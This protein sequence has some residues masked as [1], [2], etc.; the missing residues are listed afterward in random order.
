V[1]Q[2]LIPSPTGSVPSLLPQLRNVHDAFLRARYLRP[3]ANTPLERPI[4]SRPLQSHD[5]DA[6]DE[7][8]G[9]VAGGGAE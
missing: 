4:V 3:G 1:G 9:F 8:G 2:G 6:G 5:G 7:A